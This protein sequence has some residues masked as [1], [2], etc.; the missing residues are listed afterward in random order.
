MASFDIGSPLQEG[1]SVSWSGGAFIM[2]AMAMRITQGTS[3]THGLIAKN[4]PGLRATIFVQSARDQSGGFNPPDWEQV[5]ESSPG[6][7]TD[8]KK[9]YFG[10]LMQ[11]ANSEPG[12][13]WDFDTILNV[14]F[15]N[16]AKLYK[17]FG[18][19]RVGILTGTSNDI[20]IG[21]TGQMCLAAYSGRVIEFGGQVAY[22]AGAQSYLEAHKSD[23]A[24]SLARD[25]ALGAHLGPNALQPGLLVK[26]QSELT[27]QDTFPFPAGNNTYGNYKD[28]LW[29][30]GNRG[31]PGVFPQFTGAL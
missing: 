1:K 4:P 5:A 10:H 21:Y 20:S 6:G 8:P 12:E 11:N 3:I 27:D 19:T 15:I 14:F 13:L 28:L 31:Q 18:T 7:E 24:S 22:L 2:L 25:F 26:G 23:S 16:I 17:D 30:Y 29:D 9:L